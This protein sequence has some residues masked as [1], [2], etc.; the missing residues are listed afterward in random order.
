MSVPNDGAN[1]DTARQ[2]LESHEARPDLTSA[3]VDQVKTLVGNPAFGLLLG[4]MQ[5]EVQGYYRQLTYL[6]ADQANVI[7]VIQG[8]IQG[9]ERFRETVIDLFP[10]APTNEGDSR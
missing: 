10:Q 9:I 1:Q 2:W 7:A 6:P 5:A 4:Y 3:E 8:K